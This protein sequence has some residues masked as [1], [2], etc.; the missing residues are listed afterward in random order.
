PFGLFGGMAFSPDGKLLAAGDGGVL[1]WEMESG[2]PLVVQEPT[3]PE[4]WRDVV[5]AKDGKSCYFSGQDGLFQSPLQTDAQGRTVAGPR[6]KILS[7][8]ASFM[9]WCGDT[10]A[11]SG[12]FNDKRKPGVLLMKSDGGQ[13]HLEASINPDHLAA[14]PDGRWLV[15]TGYPNNGGTLWD[16]SQDPPPERHIATASRAAF[17]FTSD[18]KTLIAGTDSLVWFHDPQNPDI[19]R[20]PVRSR[21]DC[22]TVPAY[23]CSS[24]AAGLTAVTTAP[25]EVT[26]FDTKTF[27]TIL[28]LESPL[29]PFDS[30]LAFSPDGKK[31]AMAGGVSRVM[32]WDLEYIRQQLA[33]MGLDW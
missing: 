23:S 33:G 5:F 31:L 10:L 15:V 32:L 8:Y 28:K 14:S 29:T 27:R 2:L 4:Q 30:V 1:A 6:K 24:E 7:G 19:E 12:R 13:R 3:K 18:S 26:L 16:L 25:D 21:R 20:A 11:V 17:G 22:Q 9:Q